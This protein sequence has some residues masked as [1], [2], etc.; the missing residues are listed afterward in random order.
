MHISILQCQS[1]R[2]VAANLA[3]IESQLRCLEPIQGARLVVLPECCLL[4]GGHESQQLQYA[5]SCGTSDLKQT[6]ANFAKQYQVYLVAGTLPILAKDGRAY[7]R[8]YL[9]DDQGETLGH[10]DKMHL[11][12]VDVS[13]NT[14]AYR[15]SDTFCPGHEI[16]VVE[17]PFGKLGFAICYD[18]RFPELFRALRM[19]GAEI[20]VLPSAFTQVT[21]AA[22]WQVLLQAR[23]IES[24]CFVIAANQ[25]GQHNQSR[26]ETWGHSMLVDPWGTILAN[27]QRNIGWL[28]Y[29]FDVNAAKAQL[30]EIRANMPVM[31]HNRFARPQIQTK[32]L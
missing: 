31:Q 5:Q 14:K 29:E 16:C 27:Q 8:C 7:S 17:T 21:G 22:H 26:R 20:I 24:Q 1:G 6:M 13:D 15:E 18:V 11:F 4:F 23:A 9:F 28:H 19:A 25:S 3:F 12:D 32:K 10:Y 30:K 2:D